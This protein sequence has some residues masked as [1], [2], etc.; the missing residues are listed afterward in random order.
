[1]AASFAIRLG[2]TIWV[3]S[4][5]ALGTLVFLLF[6]AAGEE[7]PPVSVA[8]TCRKTVP[9][10]TVDATLACSL[11]AGVWKPK[12]F[13]GRR[14]K[15]SA[16]WSSCA[17]EMVKTGDRQDD[18]LLIHGSKVIVL[19]VTCFCRSPVFVGHL[20][21]SVTCFCRH[22]FLSPVFVT[23][24]LSPVFTRH[25]FLPGPARAGTHG[26]PFNASEPRSTD[27]SG[28]LPRRIAAS[29]IVACPVS[30]SATPVCH[31]ISAD[32]NQISRRK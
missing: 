1:V 19:S 24:F 18:Y 6:L 29:R 31:R 13:L 28:T 23:C 32:S 5:S 21:L 7:L 3:A 12:V 14:F 8:A 10:Q 4:P 9:A 25:L 17:C 27:G 26:C 22:L 16:T 15:D 11:L 30:Q 20:F 2:G